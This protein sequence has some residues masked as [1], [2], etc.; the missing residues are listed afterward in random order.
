MVTCLNPEYFVRTQMMFCKQLSIVPNSRKL[1]NTVVINHSISSVIQVLK[2]L[3]FRQSPDTCVANTHKQK[4]ADFKTVNAYNLIPKHIK[5]TKE[6][7]S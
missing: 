2:Y 7:V 5:M 3:S 1:N 4:W 6:I